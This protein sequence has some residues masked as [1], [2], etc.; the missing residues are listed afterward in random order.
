MERLSEIR[1]RVAAAEA[2]ALEVGIALDRYDGGLSV[3]EAR[4]LLIEHM[5]L[6]AALA[7]ADERYRWCI[8]ALRGEDRRPGHVDQ[9]TGRMR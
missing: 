5:H 7:A 1:A 9:G 8:E 4:W 3:E 6:T 2:Y